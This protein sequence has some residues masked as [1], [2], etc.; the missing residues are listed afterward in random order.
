[1]T[2]ILIRT[3]L[4]MSHDKDNDTVR[5]MLSMSHDNDNETDKDDVDYVTR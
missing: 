4:I 1:M 3:M 5:T 2:M